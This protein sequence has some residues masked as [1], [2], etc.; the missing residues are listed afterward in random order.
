MKCAPVAAPIKPGSTRWK[1]RPNN[2]KQGCG[3]LRAFLE[4][5]MYELGDVTPD[6][7]QEQYLRDIKGLLEFCVAVECIALVAH[8]L[9]AFERS[10]R[11]A[12]QRT[13]V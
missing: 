6:A 8:C 11:V 4:A 12:C 13:R 3:A 2:S 10:R 7:L 1:L 5:L 9:V